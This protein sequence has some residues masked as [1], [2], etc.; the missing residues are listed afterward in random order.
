MPIFSPFTAINPTAMLGQIAN[1]GLNALVNNWQTNKQNRANMALSKYSYQQEQS[2]IEQQNKYNSPVAQMARYAQAGLNPNL[3]YGQGTP[4]NQNVIAKYNAPQIQKT[5]D[6]GLNLPAAL[7]QSQNIAMNQVQTDQLRANIENTKAETA[8][9]YIDAKTKASGAFFEYGLPEY[10][11]GR[12]AGSN[13]EYK[14]ELLKYQSSAKKV[15]N[16]NQVR[17]LNA[18]INQILAS[19]G[20]SVSQ[21]LSNT[22]GTTGKDIENEWKATMNKSTIAKLFMPIVAS[23]LK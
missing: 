22:A 14:N 23:F 7:S 13:A 1:T 16:Q 15:E 18:R 21:A 9:K 3:I 10:S 19:T 6:L 12:V 4:G 2:M 17:L 5:P 20:A 11:T 8:L